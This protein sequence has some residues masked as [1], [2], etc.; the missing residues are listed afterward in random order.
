MNKVSWPARSELV[1]CFGSGDF[2]HLCLGGVVVCVRRGLKS[3]L[4]NFIVG[5][6]VGGNGWLAC[7]QGLAG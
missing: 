1:A 6:V 7:Q 5:F 2:C 3:G 4:F